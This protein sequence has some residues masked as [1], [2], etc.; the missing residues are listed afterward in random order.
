MKSHVDDDETG[1]ASSRAVEED[2]YV[3]EHET[4]KGT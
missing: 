1:D 4:A 3:H 2:S